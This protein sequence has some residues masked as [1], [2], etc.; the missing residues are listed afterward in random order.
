[1]TPNFWTVVYVS[2]F[3]VIMAL[4]GKSQGI[5]NILRRG[6]TTARPEFH[7]DPFAGRGNISPN[8][9]RDVGLILGLLGS[10]G[11]QSQQCS[12][13]SWDLSVVTEFGGCNDWMTKT[14]Y[15]RIFRCIWSPF[16]LCFNGWVLV[17]WHIWCRVLNLLAVWVFPES[18]G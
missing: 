14:P 5:T 16:C 17:M 10:G 3:A 18:L 12:K 6:S 11:H 4:N 15:S 8:K 9:K 1:V 7:G 2:I 13:T